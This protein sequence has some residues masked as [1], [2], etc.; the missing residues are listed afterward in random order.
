VL[1]GG[2]GEESSDD[3]QLDCFWVALT[4]LADQGN[5]LTRAR[6]LDQTGFVHM[7]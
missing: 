7:L 1:C 4:T 6:W 5:H 2:D 3:C